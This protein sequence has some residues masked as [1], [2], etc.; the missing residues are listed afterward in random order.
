MKKILVAI[1]ASTFLI[2]A[3]ACGNTSTNASSATASV[4]STTSSESVSETTST[5]VSSTA[6]DSSTTATP[7]LD[8]LSLSVSLEDA[9]KKFEELVPDGIVSSIE[10]DTSFGKTY[11]DVKGFNEATEYKVRIDPTTGDASIKNQE[12]LDKDE[13]TD[14]YRS[15]H[16]LD[17]LKVLSPADAGAKA[18]AEKNG[19]VVDWELETENG[20]AIY[21]FEIRDSSN[22][23]WDIKVNATSG[24]IIEI[25]K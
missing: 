5:A 21:Q 4:A 17:V 9:S 16:T 1:M 20:M 11:L 24:S 15:N 18:L 13:T 25:E 10:I 14:I 22:K 23:D 19:T 12:A 3:T 6:V 7:T 8:L 2:G